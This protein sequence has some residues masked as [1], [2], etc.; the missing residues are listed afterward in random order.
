MARKVLVLSLVLLFVFSI[1]LWAKK[2][3]PIPNPPLADGSNYVFNYLITT[4]AP[5]ASRGTIESPYDFIVG[6]TWYD[7]QHNSTF[8]HQIF[9]DFQASS[10]QNGIHCTYMTLVLPE[11]TSNRF[12]YYNYKNPAT[13]SFYTEPYS[14]THAARR[15]GY[16]ALSCFLDSRGVMIH[17][18]VN[19]GPDPD[20]RR[21]VIHVEKNSPGLHQFQEFDIPDSSGAGWEDYSPEGGMWPHGEVDSSGHVHIL[22][23]NGAG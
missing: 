3:A 11:M 2:Q 22:M 13:D 10:G 6:N 9:N 21:S 5:G 4:P 18:Y 23:R 19:A 12:M 1:S 16:G 7:Y 8:P 20:S 17:H 15:A 14:Y